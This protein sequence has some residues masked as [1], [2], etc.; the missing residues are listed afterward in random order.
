MLRSEEKITTLSPDQ[1]V[2]DCCEHALYCTVL[3][4]TEAPG[5]L[6]CRTGPVI[7]DKVCPLPLSMHVE[8]FLY[9]SLLFALFYIFG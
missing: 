9:W 5:A 3:Y 6:H 1:L 2:E 8:I 4:C 7:E